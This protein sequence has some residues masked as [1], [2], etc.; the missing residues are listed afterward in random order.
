[1][2]DVTIRPIVAGDLDD[3]LAANQDHVP[4]VGPL[5]LDRLRGLVT[6]A[7]SALIAEVGG[8]LAGF[9]IA[10]PPGVAYTSANYRW[11]SERFDDFVYVDRIVVLPETARRGLGRRLYDEV[12]AATTAEV[13]V[14]EVNTR[15]RNDVSLAFHD[16]CGFREVGTAEPYGDGIEV[17]YLVKELAGG[18]SD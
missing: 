8:A 14:A 13:L 1:M 9:V 5:D 6:M 18:A 12:V 16:R 4:A 15:P 10:L 7:E 17:V 11:V 3:L 2:A